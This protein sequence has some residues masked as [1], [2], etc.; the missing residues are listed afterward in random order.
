M[1]IGGEGVGSG[2]DCLWLGFA[3]IILVLFS[4][5]LCLCRLDGG[6]PARTVTL[7]RGDW[8]WIPRFPNC[9]DTHTRCYKDRFRAWGILIKALFPRTP[10]PL[11]F[12]SHYYQ[13]HASL[14]LQIAL[15]TLL[16][17]NIPHCILSGHLLIH[18]LRCDDS[19]PKDRNKK[20][21]NKR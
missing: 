20:L 13:M 10:K 3:I 4:W 18:E 17:N 11:E 6:R 2:G 1:E 9:I 12:Q 21:C 14:H 7:A 8:K 15:P 5:R 19:K 16:E